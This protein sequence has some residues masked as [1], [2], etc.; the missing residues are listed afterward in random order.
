M[1]AVPAGKPA[2][3]LF[4]DWLRA[5]ALL[6]MIETHVFN[7]FLTTQIRRAGWFG[8]LNF[9]NG[10]VAPSFLFV[11]GFV[12]FVASQK[13]LEDLRSMGRP[14]WRQIGKAGMI[15]A[16]GYIM[17][18]PSY[19]PLR[20]F[21][22]V[23]PQEWL[24]FYRVDVL[25][26]IS[27]TWVFLMLS[28]VAFRSQLWQRIWFF[29][30][31]L[32]LSALA[33][34]AWSMEFR[35]LLP[36]PVAAYFNVKTGSLFPVFPWSAFMLAGAVCASLFLSARRS[37]KERRLMAGLTALGVV[38]T[39]AGRLLPPLRFLPEAASTDW[40][41]DP[42]TFLLRLGLVLLL[43][44]ACFLY[45]L[46]HCPRKSLLLDVSRESLFVYVAHLLLIYGPF[47][48]GKSTADVVG[49]TQGPLVCLLASIALAALMVAGASAWGQV[50]QRKALV[51]GL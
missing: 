29:A 18:L 16:I 1:S 43:L 38:L 35:Q 27:V 46:V 20:L 42:R 41:A 23:S 34:L 45:G 12:F 25:H 39:F 13:R 14:L 15:L 17:H 24:W 48:G 5:W 28:L 21:G 3:L 32:A 50:K 19:S 8:V 44:G 10:L 47:W 11:S 22:G 4:V 36:A 30:C 40:W 2:R 26:C 37:S 7:A 49:R 6:V 9:V 51:T 31:V 33:P